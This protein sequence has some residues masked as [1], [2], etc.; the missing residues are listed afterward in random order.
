MKWITYVQEDQ[1]KLG[2]LLPCGDKIVPLS[3]LGFT[4]DLEKM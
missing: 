4:R 1:T 3:A 2:A